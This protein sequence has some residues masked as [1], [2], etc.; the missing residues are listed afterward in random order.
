MIICSQVPWL[1]INKFKTSFSLLLKFSHRLRDRFHL[2]MLLIRSFFLKKHASLHF[3]GPGS[4][5]RLREGLSGSER[6]NGLTGA[7]Q[8][9]TASA[10]SLCCCPQAA[11]L[12]QVSAESSVSLCF[13]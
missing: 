7:Q 1:K 3:C 9:Q 13:Q 2:S 10:P 6:H 4:S 12:R 11:L 5:L 8:V